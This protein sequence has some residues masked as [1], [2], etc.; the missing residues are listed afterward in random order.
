M[1]PR[2]FL[3][4]LQML[5]LSLATSAPRAYIPHFRVG[6]MVLSESEELLSRVNIMVLL[7]DGNSSNTL[8][9]C[10]RNYFFFEK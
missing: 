9:K 4:I 10:E 3:V 1:N 8:P 5:L 6:Y 2:I 7:L